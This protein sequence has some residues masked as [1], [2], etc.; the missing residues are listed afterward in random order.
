MATVTRGFPAPLSNGTLTS[1][2][3]NA[4]GDTVVIPSLQQWALEGRVWQVTVGTLSTP[5]VGG[6]AGTVLDPNQPELIADIPGGTVVVPI[7]VRMDLQAGVPT[8]DVD[9][10]EALF[11]I[12]R[13]AINGA[14]GAT[15]TKETPFNL[16]TDIIGGPATRVTSAITSDISADPTL[17]MELAHPV[18]IAVV[19]VSATPADTRWSPMLFL[20]WDPSVKPFVVGPATLVLYAGG[21]IATDLFAS[22]VWAEFTTKELG[23]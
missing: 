10:F 9:E 2:R 8:A 11:A 15:G 4:R 13:V 18:I 3:L 22:I 12:D 1:E 23:L 19:D 7:N 17:S 20:D 21:T 6:G 16:R 14:V 5:I